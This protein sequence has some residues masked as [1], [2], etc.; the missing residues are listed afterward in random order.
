MKELWLMQDLHVGHAVRP[1]RPAK[2]GYELYFDTI[3]WGFWLLKGE[4]PLP[5]KYKG[6]QPIEHHPIDQINILLYFYLFSLP[7]T[8]PIYYLLFFLRL[9]GVWRRS[10]CVLPTLE[11]PYVHQL[12]WGPSQA[13]VRRSTAS[14]SR[15]PSLTTLPRRS[16]RPAQRSWSELSPCACWFRKGVNIVYALASKNLYFDVR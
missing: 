12:W 4:N 8:F 3:L 7:Q 9:R 2:T 1:P 6:S 5:I 11:Q 10:R 15:H 16:D 13:D 14:S